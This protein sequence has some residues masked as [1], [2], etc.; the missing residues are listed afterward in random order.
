VGRRARE[1]RTI[2]TGPRAGTVFAVDVFTH[3]S[4]L[5]EYTSG[6]AATLVLSFDSPLRRS[7]FVEITGT[8]ATIA[9]PDPNGFG[10]DIRIRAASASDWTVVPCTGATNGRGL[11]VLDMARALRRGG[12]PRASG[13]I[14]LHVLETMETIE[15]SISSRAFEPVR[16]DF[17]LP[18]PLEPGWDPASVTI[19]R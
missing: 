15:R 12:S 18:E 13:E 4:A 6:P 8:E 9:L 11:G 19:C 2:A 10:G 5:I 14:G 16:G 17:T 7:G 3:I 1:T